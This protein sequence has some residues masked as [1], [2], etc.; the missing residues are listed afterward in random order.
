M[1]FS[2]FLKNFIKDIDLR[3][4]QQIKHLKKTGLR[5]SA[6]PRMIELESLESV[7]GY[8]FGTF[9][10]EIDAICKLRNPIVGTL[11]GN[12]SDMVAN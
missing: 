11:R 12:H 9:V 3:S 1:Q 5:F 10:T 4:C 2:H 8:L 7:S 6:Q